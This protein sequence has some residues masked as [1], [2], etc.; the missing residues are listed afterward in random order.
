MSVKKCRASRLLGAGL[1][2]LLLPNCGGSGDRPAGGDAQTVSV[3]PVDRHPA[4]ETVEFRPVG[5]T[6]LDDATVAV[7][8]R[9]DQQIVAL[10]LEDGSQRRAAGRGGGPGELESAFML[11]SDGAGGL[12]VGDMKA[13]RVSRFDDELAFV[14]S[15]RVPGLPVGLL[16]WRD[17]QVVAV[18]MAFKM[19]DAPSFEPTVGAID[20]AS[21]EA[22]EFFSL[23]DESS[24]LSAP[25]TDNPF[26]PPYISAVMNDDGLIL[27][28]QSMEYRIVAIDTAGTLQAIIGRRQMEPEYLSEEQKAAERAR[29]GR[30]VDRRG[31]PPPGMQPMME[32]A[33]E[34]PRPFFGPGAFSLDA[35][36]R[37][38][39]ITERTSENATEVDVFGPEGDY[40][41]TLVLAD[42]VTALA[43]RGDMMA[44]LVARTDPEIEGVAGIDLYRLEE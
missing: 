16:S 3:T 37:L 31:P 27:A 39:V 35:A 41:Q 30:A 38:W 40:L 18:W 32:E 24:G 42:R 1:L 9:D 19:S 28:G 17:G 34:A 4:L 43:F 13:N 2:L 25:E 5:L 6:W 11:L 15:A 33:L 36:G 12:I 10:G 26:A 20:F 29:L 14:E 7:L 44:A 21:G 22:R 8:D 23:F